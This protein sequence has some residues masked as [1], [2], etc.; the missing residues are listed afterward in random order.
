LLRVLPF[1]EQGPLYNCIDFKLNP[2]ISAISDPNGPIYV[3]TVSIPTFLCPTDDLVKPHWDNAD[4]G[5]NFVWST[6]NALT[7][8]ACSIGNQW[9]GTASCEGVG[10]NQGNMFGTGPAAN[11]DSMYAVDISGVFSS[12]WWSAN[13]RDITDGSSNTICM[14]EIRPKCSFWL[15]TGWM[16]MEMQWVGTTPPLNFPTCFGEPGYVPPID[17]DHGIPSPACRDEWSADNC[18]GFKSLHPGGAQFVFCDG[19][20]HFLTT[21]INYVMYQRLG[22]RR[23]GGVIGAF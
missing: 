20:V 23:D 7:N 15:R 8:Y 19:S 10:G 12:M 21:N 1:I 9:F 6:D 16:A 5:L 4:Y 3:R 13:L 22:D 18:Q 11:G 14:G 17:A 2:E